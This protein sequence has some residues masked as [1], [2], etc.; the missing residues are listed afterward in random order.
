MPTEQPPSWRVILFTDEAFVV[1]AW[2]Q[3]LAA[4]G[5]RLV[6]VVTSA[7]RNPNY[8]AVVAAA[9]PDVEV[10]VSDRPR[11]WAAMLR[12]LRPDLLVS[13]SFPWRLP[14]EL[15]DLPRLG[16]I[17]LH[18]ALLPRYRG[19]DTLHWLFRNGERVGGVTMHRMARDFD[20]GAILGQVTVTIDDD[21][22]E[23]ALM[24]KIMQATPPLVLAGLAR[25]AQGE[26]GEPQDEAQASYY[27]KIAD[28]TA[29]KTIDWTRTA[30]EVHNIVRSSSFARQLPPGAVGTLNGTPHRI[31][32]TRL[33]PETGAHGTPGT[34]ISRS[35]AEI[36]VQC[37]DAPLAIVTYE[38]VAQ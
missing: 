2:A 14:A 11:L 37:A 15:L 3:L 38:P 18:A 22:D 7:R 30:R 24:G 10:L 13:T 35:D 23:A 34:I 29:W 8:A 6:A 21:D 33:L 19:T 27:G 17:N 4:V 25:I 31:T 26:A 1:P 36:I 28:E 9:G 5:H 20:T 32:K 16:A 12:P